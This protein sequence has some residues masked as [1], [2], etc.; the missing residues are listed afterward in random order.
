MSS[1]NNPKPINDGLRIESEITLI[2]QGTRLKGEFVFDRFTRIHGDV[3]GKIQ[4]LPESLIVVGET[5][6]IHGE[7]HCVEII[8]D[9][10]ARADVYAT[11]KVTI[12]ESG[13]LIG[14]VHSPKFEVRFG[15]H[16]EG[17]A[18]T[19]RARDTTQPSGESRRRAA[20]EA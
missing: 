16:F 13:T 12:S 11:E 17:K 7:V 10:F 1:A 19:T 15:A 4:G 18:I 20:K 5:A 9:G 3:E 8:I 6:S 14:D 2:G